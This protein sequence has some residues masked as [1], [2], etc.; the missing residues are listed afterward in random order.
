MSFASLPYN[1]QKVDAVCAVLEQMAYEGY[2]E[3]I[4]TYY[5]IVLKTKLARDDT[6][7]KMLDLIRESVTNDI[8]RIYNSGF[9]SVAY[10]PRVTFMSGNGDFASEYASME[11]A[12][13]AAAEQWVDK[14]MAI[15]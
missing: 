11:T 2:H 3:V 14:V 4:P 12:A 10:Q 9:G 13:I 8:A 6:S 7:A 15:E 1:C 5:E